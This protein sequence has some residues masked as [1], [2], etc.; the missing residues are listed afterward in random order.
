MQSCER[1]FL[2]RSHLDIEGL[3][4]KPIKLEKLKKFKLINIRV[5]ISDPY[6]KK[7]IMF[8]WLNY[9]PESKNLVHLKL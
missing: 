5:L 8:K 4:I 2:Y 7:F 6:C 3:P 1:Q 9:L